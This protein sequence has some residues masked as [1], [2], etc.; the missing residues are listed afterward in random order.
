[1]LQRG[2]T[3]AGALALPRG[4]WRRRYR[5]RRCADRAA[6]TGRVPRLAQR[7]VIL[8]FWPIR[9]SS[10]NQT[11]I[12]AGGDALLARDLLQAGGEAFL[13]CSIAPVGLGMMAR[14]GR[15]LAIA[16]GAQFAAQRLLGDRDAGTPPTATGTDRSAASARPH[17]WPGIGPL[18]I[19]AASAARCASFS[20]GGWPG[21]L[22]SISPSGPCGVEPQHPVADD[23][24]RHPADP[25]RLAARCPLVDRRQ[26]QQ[27]P[28][29]G[30]IL[31]LPRRGAQ[32]AASKSVL[33][34][35]GMANLPCS[36][37]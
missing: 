4:R 3:S 29:L 26:R 27:P 8:F 7:R 6:P 20:R 36:P 1:M 13:K 18:S 31:R 25:S 15:E 19:I 9:A 5:S 22:R 28:R 30:R 24:Q 17:G 10:A 35:I 21:A 33:S 16:H 11:S 37:C 12:G 2:R 32:S 14:P 23:L 34:G